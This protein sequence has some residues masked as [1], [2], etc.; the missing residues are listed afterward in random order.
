MKKI[1]IV[2]AFLIVLLL[3]VVGC[4]AIFGVIDMAAAISVTLKVGGAIVLLGVCSALGSLLLQSS[5]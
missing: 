2:C 4:L 1:A 5:K 3:A